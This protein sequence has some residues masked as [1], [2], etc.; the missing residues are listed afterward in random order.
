[1][2][3]DYEDDVCR[4]ALQLVQELCGHRQH[5][6]QCLDFSDLLRHR[7]HPRH[8]DSDISVSL[9]SVIVTFCGVVLLG[10]SL[11]VSWKLC[12]VPWRHKGGGGGG[13]PRKDP[14]QPYGEPQRVEAAPEATQ[15]RSYMDMGPGGD[16]ALRISRTAPELPRDND[17]GRPIPPSSPDPPTSP[18]AAPLSPNPPIPP[19]PSTLSD[20]R[21]DP[22]TSLGQ[23]QPELYPP[24]P[25]GSADPRL[26]HIEAPHGAPCG[27]LSVALRYSY[28]SEQLLVRVLRARDLPHRDPGGG[29]SDPYVK[30]YLLPDRKRKFQTKVRRRTQNP[31]FE[32]TFSFAVPFAE[33]PSR[34]LHFSVYDFERFSRH[35]LIG[36]VVLDNLL[37]AAERG[38]DRP[39]WRDIVQGAAE[40]AELGEVNFSLCYLPTAGRLTV[41]VIRAANLRAM[42]L[43]GYSDPYVKASLMAEGRRL[44]KRKTSIKKNTLNPS[45][46]EALVFDV[47]HESVQHVSITIA[48]MDYDCIG[49][50]EVI[51]LCRV[52]GDA[53]GPGREHW[54]EMLA[55]P[56]TPIEQWHPLVEEKALALPKAPAREKGVGGENH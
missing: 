42:D 39:I 37:E 28:G 19:P 53:A 26:P 2:S 35:G 50:N 24:P 1:M 21:S 51:G 45:Y 48:V 40:K 8:G 33:L 20:D 14:P 46:N 34:R 18:L 3:G 31:D 4:R 36:Q 22:S 47:P 7:G 29:L 15:E 52:G 11:F 56:R 16:G 49:H 23:I 9:L 5:H 44:K 41:T 55:N 38:P 54:A 32:E 17:G 6:R 30:T 25:G 43:T 10:V 27:R 12:W 13:T